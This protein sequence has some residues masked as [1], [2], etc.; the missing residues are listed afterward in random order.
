MQETTE[1][2]QGVTV[3]QGSA[4]ISKG[5]KNVKASVK[6]IKKYMDFYKPEKRQ[7]EEVLQRYQEYHMDKVQIISLHKK[8]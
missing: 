1:E 3:S 7:F 4:I 2:L 8:V 5:W 6:K